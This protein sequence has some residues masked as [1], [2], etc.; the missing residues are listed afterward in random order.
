[1]WSVQFQ[2]VPCSSL[3][4]FSRSVGPFQCLVNGNYRVLI[5][6]S[7]RPHS[8]SLFFVLA[9]SI[10]KCL[11]CLIFDLT[12]GGKGGHYFRLT[13]SVVLWGRRNL[14]NKYHWCVWGG[15][16]CSVWTTLGLPQLTACVLSQTTLLRLQVALQGNCPKWPLGFVHFPGL[17]CSGSGSRVFHKGTESFGRAFCALPRSEQLR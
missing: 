14:M 5:C 3:Y 17:S 9:S 12:Q 8:G 16:A 13:C 2:M 1:M 7:C 11:Q 15:S 6:C 4:F 10:C